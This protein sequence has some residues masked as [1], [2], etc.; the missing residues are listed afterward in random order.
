VVENGGFVDRSSF[1]LSK[2]ANSDPE[3]AI[4]EVTL[5]PDLTSA[6]LVTQRP[7]AIDVGNG[8]TETVILEQTAVYRLGPNRWLLAPPEEA[9]WGE[10]MTSNGRYL[11]LT[12][13][14][15]DAEIGRRLALDLDRKLIEMCSQLRDILCPL[16]MR[17]T[18][19][20]TG[21]PESLILYEPAT[22]DL[23]LPTPTIL[24]MPKDEVGYESVMRGYA[25]RVVTAAIG[26]LVEYECC[27]HSPIY[28]TLLSLEWQ[29]LGL[30]SPIP[31]PDYEQVAIIAPS[32]DG[33]LDY[34]ELEMQ[35]ALY[36][37]ADFLQVELGVSLVQMQ[38]ALQADTFRRWLIDLKGTRF[39]TFEDLDRA[40]VS[41][42]QARI[43]QV[44]PPIPLPE[45]AL[46]LICRPV[47]QDQQELWRYDLVMDEWQMEW[48]LGTAVS[49]YS[50]P[51]DDGVLVYGTDMAEPFAWRD[52]VRT[53]IAPVAH[54]TPLIFDPL[55]E[56][57][58]LFD[59]IQTLSPYQLLTM[60]SCL[61][62]DGCLVNTLLGYPFWSPDGSQMVMM[63]SSFSG[64]NRDEPV[65]FL[66]NGMGF[67]TELVGDGMR[68]FW[69][70]T[71]HFGFISSEQVVS[72]VNTPDLTSE[73]LFSIDDLLAKLPQ[74]ERDS[75]D[76][77]L[78][79]Q[80]DFIVI[81]PQNSERLLVIVSDFSDDLPATHLFAYDLSH[82][83]ADLLTSIIYNAQ[84]QAYQYDLSPDGRYLILTRF[85][86]D[87]TTIR[88]SL[89]DL[90]TD[91]I[92]T[93]V[94]SPPQD[95]FLSQVMD[96]SAD[97]RWLILTEY[98]YLRLLA[99]GEDYERLI[100]PTVGGCETAVWINA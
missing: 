34:Y 28:Y 68:P 41:F 19:D 71:L 20:L 88:F 25:Q 79:I 26:H 38:R 73:P 6:E 42:V 21:D 44:E 64:S 3:S 65:L 36:V 98:G 93:S 67:E 90:Y 17:V 95:M 35:P 11:T 55:G 50:L 92:E 91:E 10:T 60:E 66:G 96:W 43:T 82:N 47:G 27:E 85:N 59:E 57:L 97:G 75:A 99:V 100:V 7:Y 51:N 8:V 94:F 22:L 53:V 15:R 2:L 14:E 78:Y 37:L 89:Y 24:G 77:L 23:A 39:A 18:V 86:R 72:V 9:F 52:E 5:A 33:L 81:D 61:T 40:W 70:D 49:L 69:L 74:V 48:R 13:P 76:L 56:N 29:Q 1:G 80:I 46:Q 63:A 16:A 30:I 12:Y 31:Q 84:E 45:Q 4:V 32:L 58:L 62:S 83:Q 54:R 87:Y